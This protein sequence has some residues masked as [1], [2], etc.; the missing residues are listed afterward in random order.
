MG[1]AGVRGGAHGAAPRTAARAVAAHVRRA[2]G[3]QA[4]RAGRRTRAL[5]G[6]RPARGGTRHRPRARAARR[7]DHRRR[8][9]APATA[10][11]LAELPVFR[12]RA[13]RRLTAY[14]FS[15]R[16]PGRPPGYRRPAALGPAERRATAGCPVGRPRPRRGRAPCR[17]P[18][19]VGGRSARSGACRWRTCSSPICCG[20]CAGARRPTATSRRPSARAGPGTGRWSS[21]P[22]CWNPPSHRPPTAVSR[23]L[24]TPC[25][26]SDT[27]SSAF[28]HVFVPSGPRR[29]A[30]RP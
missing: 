15:A 6:A 3:A 13:Q 19:R 9:A 28:Q 21:S 7:G 17:R 4:P 22:P 8:H 11:A 10:E 26:R 29:C 20:G 1:A 2:Q 5:G 24:G 16:Q 23:D 14:W 30:G 25:W 12:G 18:C 27:A